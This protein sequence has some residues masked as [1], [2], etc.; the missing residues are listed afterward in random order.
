MRRVSA[1]IICVG[2]LLLIAAPASAT[3]V[4]VTGN[5]VDAG[6]IPASLMN[7]VVPDAP[8][9]NIYL[10]AER[11]EIT[12]AIGGIAPGI[13]DIYHVHFDRFPNDS[14]WINSSG[15]VTFDKSVV[16]LVGNSYADLDA[17]DTELFPLTGTSYMTGTSGS[18]Y[19]RRMDVGTRADTFTFTGNTVTLGLWIRN[20]GMDQGRIFVNAIPEP[21]TFVLF[22]IGLVAIGLLKKRCSI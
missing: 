13:Y 2:A 9:I 1:V 14:T 18:P 10:E 11:Y 5:V 17:W 20:Q 6:P 19:Y 15:T 3:I 8:N 21:E 4:S 12:S 16:G 7:D 22:G